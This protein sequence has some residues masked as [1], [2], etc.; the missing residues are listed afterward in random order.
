M[1][2]EKATIAEGWWYPGYEGHE[3]L[4]AFRERFTQQARDL[5]RARRIEGRLWVYE[6]KWGTYARRFV[7][8][9]TRDL[10]ARDR[11]LVLDETWA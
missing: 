5:M 1:S 2:T 4:V 6:E 11:I 10:G 8:E 7:A 9:V 3:S